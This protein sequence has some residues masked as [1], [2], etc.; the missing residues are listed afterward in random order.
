MLYSS[1]LALERVLDNQH[2]LQHF[3]ETLR[4]DVPDMP[5]SRLPFRRKSSDSRN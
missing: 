1:P 5:G 2:L 3:C 4:K